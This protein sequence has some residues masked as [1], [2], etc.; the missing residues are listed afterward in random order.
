[1]PLQ[2]AEF[3]DDDAFAPPLAL[4]G[5]LW[6]QVADWMLERTVT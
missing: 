2:S 3:T 5:A 6:G 1:M 4:R